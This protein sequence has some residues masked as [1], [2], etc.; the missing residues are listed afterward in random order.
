MLKPIA[1]VN[2][3]VIKWQAVLFNLNTLETAPEGLV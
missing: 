1:N 2:K 3:F